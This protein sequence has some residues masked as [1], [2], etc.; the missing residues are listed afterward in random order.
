MPQRCTA[1]SLNLEREQHFHFGPVRDGL[2][3]G[4]L[5]VLWG[6]PYLSPMMLHRVEDCGGLEVAVK[7][8]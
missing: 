2:V 8:V 7:T 5:V 3:D 6:C 1:N 4:S